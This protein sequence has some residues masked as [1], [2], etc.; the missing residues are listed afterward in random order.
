MATSPTRQQPASRSAKKKSAA[1][2]PVAQSRAR[3]AKAAAGRPRSRAVRRKLAPKPAD[4]VAEP[5]RA[6]A[7]DVDMSPSQYIVKVDRATGEVLPDPID[8]AELLVH[9]HRD[10]HPVE[11]A[12]QYFASRVVDVTGNEGLV[13]RGLR[14]VESAG[15]GVGRLA[16]NVT[17]D[18][19]QRGPGEPA[20]RRH[21]ARLPVPV[22]R[23]DPPQREG[24]EVARA[25]AAGRGAAEAGDARQA[26]EVPRSCSPA[27]PASSARRSWPRPP[28]T[29]TSPRWR[30]SCGRRRSATA[31]RSR[32]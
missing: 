6:P 8:P 24:D 30:A 14:L 18:P 21:D 15:R 5:A 13:T 9:A 11:I 4:T 2:K 7:P 10:R 20:A 17:G 1:A 12:A 29:P 32:W 31:R 26:A 22:P 27:P 28:A 19:S 3:S 16:A 23:V 25:R